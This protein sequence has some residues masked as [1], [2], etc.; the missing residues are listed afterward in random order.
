MTPEQQQEINDLERRI[1]DLFRKYQPEQSVVL[2]LW[3]N[4]VDDVPF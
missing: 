3:R 1:V 4:V 2:N